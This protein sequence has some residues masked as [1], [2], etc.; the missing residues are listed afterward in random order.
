MEGFFVIYLA[1]WKDYS[2]ANFRT[3]CRADGRLIMRLSLVVNT[4]YAPGLCKVLL[5][6]ASLI[7]LPI[8]GQAAGDRLYSRGYG[9][10][11]T[12]FRDVKGTKGLKLRGKYRPQELMTN[13]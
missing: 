8:W 9:D 1:F 11:E 13:S 12:H 10:D 2:R 6:S 4:H 3:G 5:G 7:C